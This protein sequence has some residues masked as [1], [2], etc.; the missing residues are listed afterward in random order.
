MTFK[1][2]IGLGNPG[3]KYENTYHNVGALFARE[4]KKLRDS[5]QFI[6]YPANLAILTSELYVNES[7]KFVA[8]ELRR[9]GTNPRNLLIVQDD[10]D[11]EIGKYKFTE[12]GHSAAGHHGIESI[13]QYI[14]NHF[15]R[16]RIGIRPST[17]KNRPR[18]KAGE[19]VLKKITAGH[20]KILHD[21]FEKAISELKTL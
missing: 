18:K 20:L 15:W 16:L 5:Q 2:I 11:L 17:Q 6:N 9:T 1:L 12:P 4:F 7:G 19:F 21:V 13:Q 10:S 3:E 8:K 14:P